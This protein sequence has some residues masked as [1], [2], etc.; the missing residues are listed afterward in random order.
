[1]ALLEPSIPVYAYTPS[2]PPSVVGEIGDTSNPVTIIVWLDGIELALLSSG[3]SEVDDTGY[4]AWS[5]EYLPAIAKTRQ[6]YHYH[7]TDG[8]SKDFDGDF[9][10]EQAEKLQCM[11]SLNDKSSYVANL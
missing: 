2:A 8:A 9:I 3:C 1:M 7:M 4:Y 6:Q 11:P 10:M 5:T